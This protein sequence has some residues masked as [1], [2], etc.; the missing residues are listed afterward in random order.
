MSWC[1]SRLLDSGHRRESSWA[2]RCKTWFSVQTQELWH[3]WCSWGKAQSE[4][5][6]LCVTASRVCFLCVCPAISDKWCSRVVMSRSAQ[7][8][9]SPGPQRGFQLAALCLKSASLWF[10][11]LQCHQL[12]C[13]N[14]FT[15]IGRGNRLEGRGGIKLMHVSA[16]YAS[17]LACA[18][19]IS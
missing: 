15:Q 7:E 2:F 16:T 18:Y 4:L 1:L 14:Q 12:C 13:W 5:V 3:C 9:F 11:N 6:C 19:H 17:V 10:L 8:P